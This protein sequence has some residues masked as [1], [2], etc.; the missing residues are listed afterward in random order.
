MISQIVR[1]ETIKLLSPRRKTGYCGVE[2]IN[3]LNECTDKR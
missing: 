3:E 2:V 1:K